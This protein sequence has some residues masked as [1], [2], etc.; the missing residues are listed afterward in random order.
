MPAASTAPTRPRWTRAMLRLTVGYGLFGFGYIVPATFLPVIARDAL[1]DPRYYVWF[2]PLCGI[3]AAISALLSAPL[4]RRI[5]DRDVL[6][7]CYLAETIGVALPVVVA[8]PW[9]IGTSAVLLGGTFVVITV[10][11]LREA[12]ALAPTH[13]SHLIA[14][15]TAAFALGQIAGPIVAAYLVGPRSGF[16]LP[17][18]AAAAALLAALV[19]LPRRPAAFQPRT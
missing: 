5:R 15:M 16:A 4:A 2:W 8:Q 11:A 3:A 12:R 13:S 6:A 19:L 9:S 10:T 17:L 18:V 14:A 1:P 7:A